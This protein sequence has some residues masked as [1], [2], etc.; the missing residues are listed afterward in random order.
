VLGLADISGLVSG[1]AAVG[2]AHAKQRLAPVKAER[3][4]AF[5]SRTRSSPL[6]SS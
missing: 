6:R 2:K 1:D 3:D 5:A 4:A